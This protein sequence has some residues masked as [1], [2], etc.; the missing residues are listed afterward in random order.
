MKF[1]LTIL[2]AIS[3]FSAF[4]QKLPVVQ[5]TS[6]KKD[7]VY[8]TKFGAKSDGIMLNTKNINDAIDA[9]SKKG[10]GVV[11]IPEGLWLSGPIELKSNVNLHLKKNALLQLAPL[12][13]L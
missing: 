10:G 6:F 9:S 1:T 4:A 11:V 7:T 8:I 2:L 3:S 12:Q 13:G 5:Q